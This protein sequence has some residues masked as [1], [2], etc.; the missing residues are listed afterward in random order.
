MRYEIFKF[1]LYYSLTLHNFSFNIIIFLKVKAVDLDGSS[2]NNH[3][4]YRIQSGA[5]DKFIINAESGL[6]SVARG[7]S[8]DPDLT[9]PR[10]VVYNLKVIAFDG[11]P[12][13]SQKHTAVTV[14]ITIIDVNNK[15][16]VIDAP[17]V[18][19]VKE[20]T[21]VRQIFVR[22]I[23]ILHHR[24]IVSLQVGTKVAL[25]AAKDLDTSARLQYRLDSCEAI[26]DRGTP[27]KAADYNCLEAFTIGEAD[28][29]LKVAKVL[30]RETVDVLQLGVTVEDI[31]SDSGPQITKGITNH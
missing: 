8:L 5:S 11:A 27:L 24:I 25:I 31:A 23:N 12:G 7:A 13:Q 10:R 28:G 19:H 17:D 21:P 29:V 4:V 2:P 1:C 18:V 20:N 16:P 15:N 3:I 22:I 26:S 30:D 14:N 9:H 6:I